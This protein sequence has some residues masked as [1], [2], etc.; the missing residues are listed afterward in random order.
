[1]RG[2]LK[3]TCSQTV[4]S[5]F[6]KRK[7]NESCL[8]WIQSSFPSSNWLIHFA[9]RRIY[10]DRSIDFDNPKVYGDTSITDGLV[11]VEILNY[12]KIC[13]IVPNFLCFFK[14]CFSL[15]LGAIVLIGM[16]Y[17]L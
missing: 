17:E 13:T 8:F 12:G 1:M 2:L 9:L 10:P 14:L 16:K 15:L 7:I 3:K 4:G 5:N 11:L 6:D